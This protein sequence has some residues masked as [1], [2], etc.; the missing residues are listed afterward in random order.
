MGQPSPEEN[1]EDDVEDSDGDKSIAPTGRDKRNEMV[2]GRNSGKDASEKT[3]KHRTAD[4][5]RHHLRH[6]MARPLLGN[7]GDGDAEDSRHHHALEKT[8]EDQLRKPTRGG[9]QDGGQG[10]QEDREHDD[11]AAADALGQRSAEGSAEGDAEGCSTD[12]APDL[13]LGGVEDLLE[14]RQ[15]RLGCVEIENAPI[16]ARVTAMTAR[17]SGSSRETG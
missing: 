11:L 6:A 3:T 7:V 9:C 12:G 2:G 8:P 5:D 14:E 15:Q 1:S 16:P 17:V 10:E 13:R 4:V